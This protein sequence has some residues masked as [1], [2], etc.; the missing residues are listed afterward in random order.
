MKALAADVCDREACV[1]WDVQMTGTG[2]NRILRVSIDR[3]EGAVS[4]S[5]CERV[6]TALNLLLD[7][8]DVVGGGAYFLE[9]SSPGIERKLVEPWQFQHMLGKDVEVST[10]ER[11]PVEKGDPFNLSGKLSSVN[12]ET[13]FKLVLDSDAEVEIP[14]SAVRKA[15]TVFLD[16]KAPTK[17][18]K[19]K[20]R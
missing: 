12:G 20:K 18:E 3:K 15:K 14:F 8:K 11:M 10:S 1:L 17:G 19:K 9:V 4:V 13:S 7:A 6:S 2:R 5:D 16:G